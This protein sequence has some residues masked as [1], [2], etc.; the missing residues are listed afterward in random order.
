MIC[1]CVLRQYL[2]IVYSELVEFGL[3][4][5]TVS[6]G[7]TTEDA[8]GRSLSRRHGRQRSD[9]DVTLIQMVKI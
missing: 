7:P 9:G 8:K 2:D 4:V 5:S 6:W 3:S 1:E